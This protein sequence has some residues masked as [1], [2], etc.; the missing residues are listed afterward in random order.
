MKNREQFK[1]IITFIDACVLV[2]AVA[3]AFLFIWNDCYN[4]IIISPFWQKGNLL[5]AAVHALIYVLIAKSFNGFKVG[6][7]KPAGLVGSQIISIIGAQIVTYLQISLIGRDFMPVA[8]MMLL[9]VY[10]IIVAAIWSFSSTKLISI[11]Y[12]PKKMTIVYGGQ[13]AKELVLKMS[14]R[15]DNYLICSSISI[16][17]GLDAIKEHISNYEEVI[18]CDVSAQMRNELVKYTFDKSIKTYITPKLS[19]II[20]RGADE[21]HMFD[22]PLIIAH[23]SGPSFELRI[24]KRFFDIILSLISLAIFSPF[25]LITAIAIKLYDGG[26]VLYKQKR[27]T[28]GGKVF[29]VYKFRSMIVDAEKDGVARLASNNDDRITP[30]GKLIRKIRFDEIPQLIN[31]LKGDMSFVGPRPERPE[32]AEQYEQIIPEFS[33]RLKVKAGLTGYAQVFG[34]YNTTPYDKLKLDLMYIERQSLALD[35]R[36][37]LMTFKTIFVPDSTEGIAEGETAIKETRN[38]EPERTDDKE[39][40]HN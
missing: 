22:T 37:I 21:F 23:N 6:Y 7:L 9:T 31:I 16:N 5:L 17:E 33:F 15:M 11:L 24:F 10:D 38:S 35:F 39:K 40:I 19:D 27:L 26:S 1:R 34:K 2:A 14:S 32:I 25:M 20:V 30:I 28:I 36:I 13:S 29:D 8:P 12:P 4:D 18:I 3:G